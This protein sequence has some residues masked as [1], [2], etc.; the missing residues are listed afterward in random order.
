MTTPALAIIG[1]T[2]LADL[3]DLKYRRESFLGTPFGPPSAPLIYGELFG[4]SVVFLARH[5]PH[6]TLAP[7]KIN[8]RANLWA[9]QQSGVQNVLAIAAV[10]GI[11]PA[12][13]P[14]RLVFPDQIID[15]TCSRVNTFFEDDSKPVVHIEFTQ[16]YCE[17]LRQ[18]LIQAARHSGL[19]AFESGTYAAT[20]G[21]RLETAAE[22]D[23]LERDGCDMVGMTGMP[24][25]ALARELG[26]CYATCAVCANLAAGRGEEVLNLDEIRATL[27]GGTEKLLRLLRQVLQ[28]P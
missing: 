28:L 10:G 4:K 3:E 22:V 26:L 8:Y 25:A 9:L 20:E 12:I 13:T 19:D 21:P 18:K 24:E 6:H 15:Y 27:D 14:K 1:G 23:R 16:P 17:V 11:N 7:H 5:G 2:G